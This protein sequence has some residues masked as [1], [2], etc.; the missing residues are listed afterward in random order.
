MENDFQQVP[1]YNN[2]V[3]LLSTRY[4]IKYVEIDRIL[5]ENIHVNNTNITINVFFD[6]RSTIPSIYTDVG[7]M[8]VTK[9][10]KQKNDYYLYARSFIS[11]LNHWGRYFR[12]KK[13]NF[14]MITFSEAGTSLY[15][16]KLLKSYKRSRKNAR[17]KYSK[18]NSNLLDQGSQ[19]IDYN[20]DV[21]NSVINS[22]PDLYNIHLNYLEGDFIPHYIIDKYGM[23]DNDE[24]FNIIISSDKDLSQSISYNTIMLSKRKDYEVFNMNNVMDAIGAKK[25]KSFV[26]GMLKTPKC[27]P[28]MLAIMGDKE[29]G[30]QGLDGIGFK[31][32]YDYLNSLVE[33][34]YIENQNTFEWSAANIISLI[35]QYD[36]KDVVSKK[37]IANTEE[38]TIYYKLASFDE[39]IKNM[40]VNQRIKIEEVIE[41]K[42]VSDA[43]SINNTLTEICHQQGIFSSLIK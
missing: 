28:L 43:L 23:K 7:I 37:I 1:Q 15:H 41:K 38:F 42:E 16:T 21:L 29:D 35:N 26:Q 17:I 14:N 33:R 36:L 31:K 9:S 32:S 2:Y 25:F 12:K 18:Y 27:V 24:N 5:N 40:S 20:L 22:M 6:L 19:I 30:F 4:K 8:E 10:Y 11:L 3:N 34:T 39:L 13:L